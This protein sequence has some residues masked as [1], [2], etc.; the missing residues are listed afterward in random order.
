M[1]AKSNNV[2]IMKILPKQFKNSGK[3]CEIFFRIHALFR[4]NCHLVYVIWRKKFPNFHRLKKMLRVGHD[5]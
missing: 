2:K 4:G 3:D 5:P 1:K